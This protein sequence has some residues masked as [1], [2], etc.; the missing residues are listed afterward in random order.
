MGQRRLSN[1][2]ADDMSKRPQNQQRKKTNIAALDN[3]STRKG[4]V[5]RAQRRVS[6]DVNLR[7]SQHIINVPVNKSI[8]NGLGGQ[9]ISLKDQ[10]KGQRS[11]R[12]TLKIIPIGG[13]GEMGIGKNM[14][15]FEFDDEIIVV[16][17]GFFF[18]GSDYPG[19]NYII[20]DITW[21]EEKKHRIC[22][23]N[24]TPGHCNCISLYLYSLCPPHPFLLQ[25]LHMKA[26]YKDFFRGKKI[27]L[28]GLGLLGRGIGEAVCQHA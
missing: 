2:Q 9:Q 16:D 18:L 20:P 23:Q 26:S 12:A 19:I 27:T 28:M 3:P 5:F 7:A 8:Y 10:P 25:L 4:E 15:A 14:T 1:P 11:T 22:G 17:M 6:D 21:L 13:V 24:F